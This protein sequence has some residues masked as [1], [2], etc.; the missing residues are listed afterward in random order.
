MGLVAGR[1]CG[2]NT[3][4]RR[5]LTFAL[6]VAAA[7]AVWALTVRLRGPHDALRLGIS[8]IHQELLPFRDLS[9][10]ANIAIHDG[11]WK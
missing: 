9:V 4:V 11:K 5:F 2:Q 7:A 8:M 6:L 1:L 10:A 3:P